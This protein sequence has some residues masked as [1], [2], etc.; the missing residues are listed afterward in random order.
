MFKVAEKCPQNGIM[1]MLE[2]EEQLISPLALKVINANFK[3]EVDLAWATSLYANDKLGFSF[4]ISE[5]LR[6][7]KEFRKYPLPMN[8]VVAFRN[9]LFLKNRSSFLDYRMFYPLYVTESIGFTLLKESHGFTYIP[10]ILTIKSRN[11]KIRVE[12]S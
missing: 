10:E 11:A 2:N 3:P 5:K 9:A 4:N 7:A 1:L 12:R 6:A 8:D